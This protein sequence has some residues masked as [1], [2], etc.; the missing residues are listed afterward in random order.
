MTTDD[1]DWMG[2]P[3]FLVF[4]EKGRY[5]MAEGI[6]DLL[7]NKIYLRSNCLKCFDGPYGAKL[8]AQDCHV[9]YKTTV[10]QQYLKGL[11]VH[12]T[13]DSPQIEQRICNRLSKLSMLDQRAPFPVLRKDRWNTRR[14]QSEA[15]VL[16]RG[17]AA[18]GY[19]VIGTS[20]LM[21]EGGLRQQLQVADMFIVN[22]CRWKGYMRFLLLESLKSMHERFDTVKFQEPL[23][24]AGEK[25]LDKI[26][27]E[28]G[29]SYDTC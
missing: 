22:Y 14:W 12:I 20:D 18:V 6:K 16:V 21:E 26:A 27:E 4:D 2:K 28:L 17:A 24:E 5:C 8:H 1:S 3:T 13:S 15:Y 9:F 23:S 25:F 10:T 11:I 19:I 7:G 29:Q